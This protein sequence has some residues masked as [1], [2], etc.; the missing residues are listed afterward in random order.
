MGAPSNLTVAWLV[1]VATTLLPAARGRAQPAPAARL[2]PVAALHAYLAKPPQARGDLDPAIVTAPLT[3]AQAQ[4]CQRMIVDDWRK[5]VRARRAG[6]LV[7][8]AITVDGKTMRFTSRTLGNKPARG[9]SLFISMHGGGAAPAKVNDAQWRN[10]QV[11]YT[12]KE[13]IY[14]APRAPTDTWNMWHEPHIDALFQRLIADLIAIEDVDPDRIYLMGYSAGGDGV[15]QLAPRMADRF[16]AAAMMAGHPN[17]ASPI[18]LR[19][20]GFAIHVGALDADY[21]RNQVAAAWGKQLDALQRDPGSYPHV[22]QLHAGKGHWM[23]REDAEAV[24]WM[25]KFTRRPFPEHVAWK[26]DDVLHPR[27]YWLAVPL[28]ATRAGAEIHAA[29]RGQTITI[30]RSDVPV[31]SVR[32]NDAMLDLDQPV[33]IRWGDKVVFQG[34]VPRTIGALV[35]TLAEDEDPNALYLGQ[36]VVK[37]PRP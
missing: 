5:L 20:I 30:E 36:V 10:Q 19:N 29:R 13:G 6:E 21:K 18:G 3:R 37:Q 32:V 35:A 11:L 8:H 22:V 7:R 9:R 24:P 31:I 26:Q 12:P 1:A 23:D 27:F 17:D 28:Q 34:V 2:D 15:Y 16:A 4:A 33:T 14:V 25:A